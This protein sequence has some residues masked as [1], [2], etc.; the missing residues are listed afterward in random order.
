MKMK[1]ATT[2]QRSRVLPA[3]I[4]AAG[5]CFM[6][7][8]L[9]ASVSLH[10]NAYAEEVTVEQADYA[11]CQK[12]IVNLN[13]SVTIRY[14]EQ[15]LQAQELS[16]NTQTGEL[17]A[18][19]SV[20]LTD[21]TRA[22][23]CNYLDYNLHEKQG[24]AEDIYVDVKRLFLQ[25]K[26]ARIGTSAIILRHGIVTGCNLKRPH[27]GIYASSIRL[28]PNDRIVVKNIVFKAANV[29]FFYFPYY[30]Q[31][32]KDNRPLLELIPSYA[33]I[34]GRI[35]KSTYNY[36]FSEGSKGSIF[37]DYVEKRGIGSGFSHT[38]R[39]KNNQGDLSIYYINESQKRSC[40]LHRERWLAQADWLYQKKDLSTMLH[41]DALSDPQVR[42]DYQSGQPVFET[43]SHLAVTRTMDSHLLR[44]TYAKKYN[45]QNWP[46]NEFVVITERTPS[47]KFETKPNRWKN[48][49]WFTTFSSIAQ[50]NTATKTVTLEVRASG[51]RNYRLT[52]ATTL[53]HSILLG[54]DRKYPLWY[55]EHLNLRQRIRN[56]NLNLGYIIK[57]NHDELIVHR[58]AAE[59]F[60]IKQDN[61]LRLWTDIDLRPR[62][63]LGTN[64]ARVNA[65]NGLWKKDHTSVQLG[66]N[67]N[68]G[69]IE[70]IEGLFGLQNGL[71]SANLGTTYLKDTTWEATTNCLL[72]LNPKT[73]ARGAA[74]IQFDIYY[75]LK[76]GHVNEANYSIKKDLHCW[77]ARLGFKSQPYAENKEFWI[78][79]N[80][81]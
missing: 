3:R 70:T 49:P 48:T 50:R 16:L 28:Y 64:T 26:Q 4:W 22:I 21:S 8:C 63:Q 27:Y 36:L 60:Q 66:F 77:E 45:W 68:Q 74:S 19:G 1:Q 13:G 56:T 57:N 44:L 37:L 14:N 38:N 17:T 23:E 69:K 47:L 18:T 80:P 62:R 75:D 32:L 53:T 33:D 78:R 42:R 11:E 55:G 25:A 34:D 2:T 7:L 54:G 41:L 6:L 76:N 29:P 39:T 24:E 51:M 52:K 79:I 10:S 35:L 71:F 20:K 58:L 67:P 43:A 5:F 65:I 12:T 31:S 81:K 30:S 9:Y 61:R 73:T 59:L 40:L 15:L 46:K 72:K